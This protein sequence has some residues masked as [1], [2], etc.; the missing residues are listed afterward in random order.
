[1]PMYDL[2][3]GAP[4]LAT[5]KKGM[6]YATLTRSRHYTLMYGILAGTL[7]CPSRPIERGFCNTSHFPDPV[8]PYMTL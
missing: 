2:L 7:S 6:I 4:N 3:A 8:R 1:M 5:P